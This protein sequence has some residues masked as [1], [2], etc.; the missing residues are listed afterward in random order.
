MLSATS[1]RKDADK[2]GC[3]DKQ[4]DSDKLDDSDDS[5]AP[6]KANLV[7]QIVVFAVC[8]ALIVIV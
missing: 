5:G 1:F 8:F 2:E 7:G 4:D 3:T 6:A